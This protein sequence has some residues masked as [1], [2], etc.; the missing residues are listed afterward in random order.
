M[1]QV[2]D[3]E[4]A[5]INKHACVMYTVVTCVLAVA[6]LAQYLQGSRTLGVFALLMLADLGPM[7]ACH[8]VK[9]GTPDSVLIRHIMG[10]GYGI[11]YL[12]TCITSTE[13]QVYVYAIPM[14]LV[15]MLF[16]DFR[17]S[18]TI[19]VGVAII[20]IAHAV[21]FAANNQF[22]H[23]AVAAMEIEIA[24]MI[25]VAVFSILINKI[26]VMLNER[27]VTE[28]HEAG[29]KTNAM[30]NAVMELSGDMISEVEAVSDKMTLLA[31]SSQETL[32][33]MQEIQTG[34]SDCAESVQTQLHKT[35]EIQELIEK[36]TGAAGNIGN[37]I[38]VTSDACSEG[39]S[40]IGKLI[41]QAKVSEKAG[42]EVVNEV[43]SLKSSTTKMQSIVELIQSVAS[44]TSMLALN[45]SIE[46]A[47][48]GEAGRGFAVVAT[49]ISNL[50]SQTQTATGNIN[51]LIGSIVRAMEEVTGAID[52]L[53]ESNQLQNESAVVTGE[54]FEKIIDSIHEIDDNSEE[55]SNVVRAL[56]ATNQ[57][58]VESIQTISAVTE[59]VSAHSVNT[60]EATE[61]NQEI[62]TEVQGIVDEMNRHAEE[63]NKLR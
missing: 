30:L 52:S 63:L 49:E 56:S 8:V 41:E 5:Y 48:A 21:Y 4:K 27:K 13:Q 39:R 16:N 58:I 28:I 62:V 2:F 44:Q 40:N 54:S 26:I 6:Y 51:D 33:S 17:F 38:S 10:I 53:V 57:E 15:V 11:F 34:T 35:E 22:T 31:A 19:S 60:C 50:A 23:E 46:A 18:V 43:E 24:V 55:L 42:S 59:E 12:L 20:S 61:Q 29:D 45:A 47:R 3:Q 14:L 25:L 9:K 37:S 32:A 1:E 36:V 7:I